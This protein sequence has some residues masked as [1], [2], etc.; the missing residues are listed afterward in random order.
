MVPLGAI[1][2][3]PVGGWA[4][5]RLGRKGTIMFCVIPFELGW[6]LLAYAQN[7]GMLYAG[8]II[9]GLACGIISLAVP[10]S[11][12]IVRMFSNVVVMDG[13]VTMWG[14]ER[15][16]F[17][18]LQGLLE[19]TILIYTNKVFSYQLLQRASKLCLL[20]S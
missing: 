3:G 19:P 4:I 14:R 6:L 10:V 1:F 18:P 2:G 7:R 11:F 15:G 8:R 20:Y 9:T 16:R 5:D 13:R 12:G 17:F